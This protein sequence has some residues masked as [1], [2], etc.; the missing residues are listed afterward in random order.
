MRIAAIVPVRAIVGGKQRLAGVLDQY[1]RAR[2]VRTMLD[3][4]LTV[5]SKSPGLT[6]VCV[7]SR[8]A[9]SA[10]R[11]FRLLVDGSDSLNAALTIAA[12]TLEHEGFDGVLVIPAD[13]PFITANEV[14]RLLVNSRPRRVLIV[15]DAAGDG[16]NALLLAPPRIVQP[17]FGEGSCA[18]HYSRA[19]RAGA[20]PLLLHSPGIAC[21]IDLP[22]DLIRLAS[23]GGPRYRFLHR[24]MRAA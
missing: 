5:L 13:L 3:T 14:Q 18:A 6:D 1:G 20:A 12:S 16:T 9:G 7:L 24:A 19:Y 23:E 17:C 10:P 21:D 2:L 22:A 4:V 15:P 11:G 8:D